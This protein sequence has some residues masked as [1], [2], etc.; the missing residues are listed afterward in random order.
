M[1]NNLTKQIIGALIVSL[2][3]LGA[4]ILV[5]KTTDIFKQE[6]P[7]PQPPQ[8]KLNE[9]QKNIENIQKSLSPYKKKDELNKVGIINNFKNSSKNGEPTDSFKKKFQISGQIS[10]GYLYIKASVNGRALNQYDGVYIK[11]NGKINNEYKELGG[12]LI[13]IKGTEETPKSDNI[14][15]L[16]YDLSD[17]KYKDS[18]SQSDIEVKSGD[19]LNMINAGNS[20]FVIGFSS[21]TGEGNIEEISIYYQCASGSECSIKT[22]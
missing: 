4:L 1:N 17:V 3:S 16:L 14:T 21:T 22:E 13:K 10:E 15:E 18:Y 6:T 12:H 7:Q 8:E 20:Q 11:L 2:I 19:W 9:I 5:Y